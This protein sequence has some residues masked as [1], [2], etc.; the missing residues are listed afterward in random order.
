MASN[1]SIVTFCMYSGTG[2]KIL[3]WV[4]VYLF[5]VISPKLQ[6]LEGQRM[7]LLSQK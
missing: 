2:L 1:E 5:R 3:F 4:F 7:H 6:V